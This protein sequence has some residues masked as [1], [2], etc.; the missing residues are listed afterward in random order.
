MTS[1]GLPPGLE[2]RVSVR[3]YS[4]LEVHLPAIEDLVAFNLYA[5][6]DLGERSKHFTDLIELEPIGE[7]LVT[8]A[9]WTRTHDPSPG[10]RDELLGILRLLGI[11]VSDGEF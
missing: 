2:Q 4:T 5:A 9:R 8:A 3:H 11:E 10:F 1:F 6:V 7:Q